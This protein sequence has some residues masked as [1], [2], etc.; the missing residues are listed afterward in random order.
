MNSIT[1]AGHQASI[2]ATAHT[3]VPKS[4]LERT[5]EEWREADTRPSIWKKYQLADAMIQERLN[6]E[7]E[8]KDLHVSLLLQQGPLGFWDGIFLSAGYNSCK[9]SVIIYDLDVP[10]NFIG[11]QIAADKL[12]VNRGTT[13]NWMGYRARGTIVNMGNTGNLCGR[14]TT[15][16]LVNAGTTGVGFGEDLGKGGIAISFAGAFKCQY[17]GHHL[18]KESEIPPEMG[19]YIDDIVTLCKGS[20]DGILE[21][22]GK[23]PSLTIRKDLKRILGVDHD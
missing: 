15:G 5:F 22:Y 3:A 16:S 7:V 19:P 6:G 4:E 1:P 12:L 14:E 9:E 17:V 20:A 21:V 11:H 8:V 2:T 13:G 18:V 10:V 23:K